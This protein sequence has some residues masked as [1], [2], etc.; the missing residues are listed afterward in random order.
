MSPGTLEA[1]GLTNATEYHKIAVLTQSVSPDA[2]K[3]IAGEEF[4]NTL[5]LT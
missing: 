3:K 2:H 1:A 4:E 5:C